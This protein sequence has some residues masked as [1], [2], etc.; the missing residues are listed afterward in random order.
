VRQHLD[1]QREDDGGVLFG[2]DAIERLEVAQ[3]QRRRRLV[4]DVGSFAQRLRR[5]V[6]TFRSDHLSTP[7]SP[8]LRICLSTGVD[9]VGWGLDPPPPPEWV[10]MV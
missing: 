4:D 6:L 9:T 10:S 3:L 1:R 5:S 7:A 2:R 8:H